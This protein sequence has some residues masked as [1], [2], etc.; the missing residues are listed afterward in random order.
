MPEMPKDEQEFE[1]TPP[2]TA[3]ELKK[4]EE[5]LVVSVQLDRKLEIRRM[6]LICLSNSMKIRT[7]SDAVDL[8]QRAMD[9]NE[10]LD[11][12]WPET[13]CEALAK[14]QL[15]YPPVRRF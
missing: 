6:A 1:L 15:S 11:T 14:L 3:E 7:A 12:L 8:A 2:P 5:E 13:S 4:Q 10:E 9:A